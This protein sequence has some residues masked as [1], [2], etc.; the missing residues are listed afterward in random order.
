MIVS[1]KDDWEDTDI[2]QPSLLARRERTEI[3]LKPG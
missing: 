1:D 2:T 3:K